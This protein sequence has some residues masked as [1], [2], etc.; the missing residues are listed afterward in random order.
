MVRR[1]LLILGLVVATAASSSAAEKGERASK[2]KVFDSAAIVK[3]LAVGAK[4]PAAELQTLDGQQTTLAKVLSGE[5]TVLIFFRG[6]WCPYCN[7]HLASLAK[8]LPELKSRGYQV[9]AISPD[10]AASMKQAAKKHQLELTLLSDSDAE[11]MRR[12]GLAFRLDDKTLKRYGE[13]GIRLQ[14]FTDI[15]GKVLPV[16]AVF[17]IDKQGVISFAH[18]DADYKQRLSAEKILEAAR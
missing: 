2:Q 4:V 9:V 1:A 17:L 10:T 14:S 5:P 11:A 15:E 6:G 7:R 16:P 18:H 12:F 13:F 3:P 8:T